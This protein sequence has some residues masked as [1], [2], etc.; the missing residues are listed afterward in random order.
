MGGK[1]REACGRCSVS[2]VVDTVENSEDGE[3]GGTNPFD[4]ERIELEE[5]EMRSVVRHEVFVRKVKERLDD[6]AMRLTYGK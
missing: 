6:I 1:Q 5:S 3:G 2:A 4:G